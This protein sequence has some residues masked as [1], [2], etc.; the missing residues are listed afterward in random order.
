[1]RKFDAA[2]LAD[3]PEAWDHFKLC[4]LCDQWFD[5]RDAAAV[6]HHAKP[7]H[8]QVPMPTGELPNLNSGLPWHEGE[9]LDLRWQTQHSRRVPDIA[10]FMC[11]TEYEI[12]QKAREVGIGELPTSAGSRKK[13]V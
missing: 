9:L 4:R 10:D 8:K 3:P 11:R 1:M 7:G 12:R 6:R 2:G 5:Q 13:R